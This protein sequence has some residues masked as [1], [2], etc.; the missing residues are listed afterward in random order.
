MENA[1]QRGLLSIL[2]NLHRN[3][4]FSGWIRGTAAKR[5]EGT[6]RP[7]N[8]FYGEQ[9]QGLRGREKRSVHLNAAE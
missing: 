9:M 1:T 3:R 6:Q 4:L 2:P 7:A 5:G 8:C